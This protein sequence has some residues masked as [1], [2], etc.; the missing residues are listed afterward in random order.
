MTTKRSAPL[1]ASFV[2]LFPPSVTAQET[3][4]LEMFGGY[5]YLGVTEPSRTLLK[6]TN[7]NG[8]DASIKLN[9]TR[10]VGLVADFSGHYGQRGQNPFVFNS[11]TGDRMTVEVTP[12]DFRQHTFLLGPEVRLLKRDRL[13]VNARALMG[14]AH[15]N[16]LILKFRRNPF[17]TNTQ[18]SDP[19]A[20][21]FAASFGGSVDYRITDRLSYRLVQPELLL[22]RSG[23]RD[24][25]TWNQYSFR[26]S[27]GLVFTSGH[28][29]RPQSS[30]RQFFFGIVGGAALTDAFGHESTGFIIGPDGLEPLRSRSYSSLRDYLIGP[31]IEAGLP[32]GGLS[33]EIDVL[34]RPMNLTTAGVNPDGSLH[35][36]SPATVVTWQFPALAKYRLASGPVKPFLEAGPSF[37]VSGNLNDALPSAYG[38]TA[39]LGVETQLGRFRIGPVVRYTHWAGDDGS[40][41]S[42]TRRNQVELLL[43]VSF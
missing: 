35:S 10:K 42:R 18:R 31:M 27:T 4:K 24:T 33:I 8:W 9:L 3:P 30:G 14:V 12:G 40:A 23:G 32:W 15:T 2:L 26:L 43:G 16:T 19:S 5:S 17:P 21:G 13:S 36:V 39:G 6:S 38:G 37:R 11:L 20:N 41:G 29:T 25:G 22:T 34:Y 28:T 7:L 1:I